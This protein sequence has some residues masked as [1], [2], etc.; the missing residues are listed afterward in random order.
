MI[1]IEQDVYSSLYEYLMGVY[2]GLVVYDE[3]ILSPEELPCVCVEEIG[4]SVFQQSIDSGSNEN[5]VVVDYEVRVYGN[6]V[7]GKKSEVK[8]IFSH[9]DGWF[10]NNGFIRMSTRPVTFDDSTKYQ[11]IGRYTAVVDKN[12]TIYRR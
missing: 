7:E 12:K 9:V 2:P 3:T 11:F 10:L 8:E 4:N 1:D 5:H 6:K